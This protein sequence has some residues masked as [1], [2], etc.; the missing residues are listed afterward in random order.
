M[1]HIIWH[2]ICFFYIPVPQLKFVVSFFQHSFDKSGLSPIY[3]FYYYFF[4]YLKQCS[5]SSNNLIF[6]IMDCNK[7]GEI[8]ECLPIITKQS[9]SPRPGV[10]LTTV[11]GTHVNIHLRD[12]KLRWSFINAF[13]CQTGDINQQ[14]S[15]QIHQKLSSV[16]CPGHLNLILT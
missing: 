8:L 2:A 14:N 12:R 1:C 6:K 3:F 7:M 4:F 13:T 15:R 9:L 5:V 10:W 11:T 16:H